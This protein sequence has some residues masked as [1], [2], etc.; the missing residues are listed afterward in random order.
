MRTLA[1]RFVVKFMAFQ[2]MRNSEGALWY[3]SFDSKKMRS[4][5][6][7]GVSGMCRRNLLISYSWEKLRHKMIFY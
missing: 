3:T 7:A 1:L 4:V 2:V 5:A 6:V